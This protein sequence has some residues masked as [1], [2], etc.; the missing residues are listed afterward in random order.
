[1]SKTEEEKLGKRLWEIRMARKWTQAQLAR[2]IGISRV[3]LC[4]AEHGDFA[5]ERSKSLY[6]IRK[7]LEGAQ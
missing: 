6:L 4:Q 1:M 2:T 3:A 7:F 5:G